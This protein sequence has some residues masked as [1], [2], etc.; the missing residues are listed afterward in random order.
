MKVLIPG[1]AGAVGQLAA[2]QFLARGH[3]VAGIDRR[4]WWDAPKSVHL[5][6]ID[7]RKRASEDVF[8]RF[9]PD[10]VV[11]MGT[12]THLQRVSDD[13]LRVNLGGTRAVFEHAAAYG[14]KAV[15]FVGRHTFYG[16]EP[17]APLYHKEEEPPLEVATFP[18]LAD[19][20]AADL[21][22]GTALWRW[23]DIDTAVLRLC[24]TLGRSHH[25]TLARYIKPRRVPMVFGFDPLFQFMHEEDAAAA[26]V[27]AAEKKLRGVFNV[28][29]PPPLPLS[30]IVK[31]AGRTPIPI[32]EPLLRLAL[33]RFGFSSLPLG[34]IAHIKYPVVAD[35]TAF[36]KATGFA[37]RYS[38]DDAI[39]AFRAG[40]R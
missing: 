32:P 5:H 26:V 33:G 20:V 34:A 22:A 24:Y 27:L 8:R 3:E 21:Y 29:G 28:A 11:H 31:T 12:V 25:G 13:Q 23:P 7:I 30:M 19:L 38:E 9:R 37:N 4:K 16:A 10:V 1:I 36:R 17:D 14:V 18:E 40:E 35:A 6:Q 39:A 15:V 2:Q